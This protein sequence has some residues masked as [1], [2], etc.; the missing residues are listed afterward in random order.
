[1]LKNGLNLFWI[2]N[3]AINAISGLKTAENA[4]EGRFIL[5]AISARSKLETDI[6]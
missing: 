6:E 4:S 2:Y 1:M 3:I 5:T